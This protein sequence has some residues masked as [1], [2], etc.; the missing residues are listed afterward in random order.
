MDRAEIIASASLVLVQENKV[1]IGNEEYPINSFG[2]FGDS[3]N[4]IFEKAI[5][6]SGFS[7]LFN[8]PSSNQATIETYKEILI[9]GNEKEL[10]FIRECLNVANTGLSNK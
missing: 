1:I 9:V 6:I 10:K 7:I 8:I 3:L 5:G 2:G 4:N